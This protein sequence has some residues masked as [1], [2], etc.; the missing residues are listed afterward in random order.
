M[1]GVISLLDEY[2]EQLVR[3]IWNKLQKRLGRSISPDAR[4]PHLTWHVAEAYTV[5]Y[6]TAY[7]G[8]YAPEHFLDGL[9]DLTRHHPPIKIRTSGI[10]LFYHPVPVLYISLTATEEVLA[11]QRQIYS[12]AVPLATAPNPYFQ[13]GVWVPHLTLAHHNFSLSDL[14]P[15]ADELNDMDLTW[16]IQLNNVAMYCPGAEGQKAICRIEFAHTG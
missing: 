6:S 8:G 15:A 16:E 4:T 9:A 12:Y 5:E 2:S 11:F 14:Q 10:G 7:P 3:Q 13:P 1:E